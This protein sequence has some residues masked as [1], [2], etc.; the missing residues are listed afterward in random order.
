[1]EAP[2]RVGTQRAP[3]VGAPILIALGIAVSALGVYLGLDQLLA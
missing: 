2:R 1:M 3:A